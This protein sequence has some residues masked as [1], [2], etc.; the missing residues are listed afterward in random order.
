MILLRKYTKIT[1]C[2][3]LNLVKIETLPNQLMQ[4]KYL[5]NLVST[6]TNLNH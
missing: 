2:P 3:T 1:L 4:I 6:R 5:R